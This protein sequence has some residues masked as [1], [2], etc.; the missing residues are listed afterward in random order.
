MKTLKILIAALAL[1]TLMTSC[2]D[3]FMLDYSIQESSSLAAAPGEVLNFTIDFESDVAIQQIILESERLELDY[4][5][6]VEIRTVN[7]TRSFEVVIPSD[8]NSG[9]II[10]IQ[11]EFSS[12][13]GN[14]LVDTFSIKVF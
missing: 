7:M 1:F 12:I 14:S 10:D 9:E 11:L 3:D 13:Q 8:A 2:S 5:E 4:L 6:V